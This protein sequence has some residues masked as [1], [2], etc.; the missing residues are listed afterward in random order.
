[1]PEDRGDQ[2]VTKDKNRVYVRVSNPGPGDAFDVTVFVRVSEP[3]QTVGG[4]TDWAGLR[5]VI[6]HLR[7]TPSAP[8]CGTGR[9]CR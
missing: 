5:T 1:M 9:S 4:A 3:Y 8:R 6:S 2:P 7:S